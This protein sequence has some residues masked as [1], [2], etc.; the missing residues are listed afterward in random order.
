MKNHRRSWLAF[1]LLGIILTSSLLLQGIAQT[2]PKPTGS[3]TA[4]NKVVMW[5][6]KVVMWNDKDQ[7]V[8]LNA[9]VT[10]FKDGQ[11]V[12]SKE[13]DNIERFG[14]IQEAKW[15]ELPL[16]EYEVHFEVHGYGKVIK[17]IVVS[18][19]DPTVVVLSSITKNDEVWGGGPT[20]F[21][22]QSKITLL[23]KEN[24]ELK[25]RL[26]ALEKAK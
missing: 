6:D 3:V 20:L 4:Y 17:R 9:L 16:G 23:E 12:R 15:S 14:F 25:E 5:N 10:L 13:I 1:V 19:D 21:D 11:R 18:P 2:Q 24:A 26:S 22:L 8:V 7:Q